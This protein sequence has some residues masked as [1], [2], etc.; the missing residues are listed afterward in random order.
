[1]T[2]FKDY[3]K[4]QI[5]DTQFEAQFAK[6]SE[7]R[8][9]IQYYILGKLEIQR[10]G[11]GKGV[12]PGDHHSAKNHI[13]HILPKRLSSAQGRANEWPWARAN[14]EKHR[15][16]VNR[17]GNLLVLEGDIN[18][19]VNNHEFSVKQKGQYKK[20]KSGNINQIKCYKDSALYWPQEICNVKKWHHWTEDEIDARQKIMAKDALGIWS[21]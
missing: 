4:N 9:K 18:R 19:S 8:V 13:E 14:P 6:H 15:N 2:E 12:V 7:R 11:G 17:L 21:I 10:L 20:N 5:N 16:L 1:M 3:L